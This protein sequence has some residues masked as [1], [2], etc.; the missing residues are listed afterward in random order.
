MVTETE[1][2]PIRKVFDENTQKWYFSVVDVVGIIVKTSDPRNYWKVLKSRLK[3]RQNELVT[4]C[5]QLKMRSNDGKFYLTDAG[6]KET[7]L[8]I[9]K[10]IAPIDI[11]LFK[12]Y[13]DTLDH[14]K[15]SKKT[16]HGVYQKIEESTYLHPVVR[17]RQGPQLHQISTNLHD[18]RDRGPKL[19]QPKKESN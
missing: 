19:P 15:D 6:D 16:T 7:I 9:V 18:L 13:F 1:N 2:E 5:N 12:R 10:M 11:P 14:K 4:M 3:K 17:E 8:K